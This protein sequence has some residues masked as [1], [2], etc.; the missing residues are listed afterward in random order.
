[1]KDLCLAVCDMRCMLLT[2]DIQISTTVKRTTH[3]QSLTFVCNELRLF[4][5]PGLK[6]DQNRPNTFSPLPG[7]FFVFFIIMQLFQTKAE[8][9]DTLWFVAL[10]EDEVSLGWAL[11]IYEQISVIALPQKH[12]VNAKEQSVAYQRI[13]NTDLLQICRTVICNKVQIAAENKTITGP[14]CADCRKLTQKIKT[15]F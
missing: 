10:G 13:T 3:K 14:V 9:H 1:M 4:F 7:S 11:K 5:S 6:K 8:T 2:M 12:I 15:Y